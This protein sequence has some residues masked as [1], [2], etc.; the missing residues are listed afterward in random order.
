M[1][2]LKSFFVILSIFQLQIINAQ[3]LSFTDMAIPLWIFYGNNPS[4]SIC[5]GDYDNENDIDLYIVKRGYAITGPQI[6]NY[7]FRN[8]VNT[9]GR[10]YEV[11]AQLGIDEEFSNSWGAA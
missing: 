6:V 5:W 9:D 1:K 3:N 7:L 8:D 11:A 10:F 2:Y 4:G